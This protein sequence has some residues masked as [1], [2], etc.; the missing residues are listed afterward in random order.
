[1]G[2][3]FQGREKD[4][5]IV[6]VVR[7]NSDSKSIGFVRD[8]RRMNVAFTRARTNL[9]VVGYADVLSRNEDWKAF[10]G[11]QRESCRLLRVTRPF[12]G[13]LAR[14]LRRWYDRN[15]HVSR[16]EVEF[17]T[18][19]ASADGQQDDAVV[20]VGN[21][22]ISPEELEELEKR[23]EIERFQRDVEE[24]SASEESLVAG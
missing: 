10:V 15:P 13:F 2:D 11:L 22:S 8:R 18:E 12:D 7:A 16:P 21:F 3:G 6:S 4:C 20:D 5:I 1:M 19:G 24:V 14:Y 9:W 23:D 17:L